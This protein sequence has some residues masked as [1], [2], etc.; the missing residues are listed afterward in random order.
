MK[1]DLLFLEHLR[2]DLEQ[3]KLLVHPALN[4]L[5]TWKLG[6]TALALLNAECEADICSTT[7]NCLLNGVPWRVIGKGSNLLMPEFWPGILIRLGKNFRK[8][9]IVDQDSSANFGAG[10]ADATAAQKLSHKGWSGLEFL[11]GIPGT[12]GGAICM[13][14]GAHGSQ[15]CDFLKSVDWLDE[16]GNW[17]RSNR[18]ELNFAY[19][20]SPFSTSKKTVVL[21]ANF[22]L[23]SKSTREVRQKML[24]FHNFRIEKQPQKHPNCGSVF[25]NPPN[26]IAAELIEAS[27]LKGKTFGCMQISKVHSNF[28][29]NLGG[30][31]FNDALKLIEF[32]KDKIWIDHKIEL[33][34][35]VHTLT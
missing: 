9:E 19:R 21:M 6:G 17:R 34:T 7:E 29:V 30:A 1:N 28:M 18:E 16:R 14:A 3:S 13:N 22:S 8:L 31:T 33:S 32:V 24:E 20:S 27:G 25:R 35:E 4:R 23:L 11:I 2:A 10:V 12:I 26:V 5:N 15:I